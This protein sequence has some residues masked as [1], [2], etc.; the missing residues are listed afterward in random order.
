MSSILET[1]RPAVGRSRSHD[2]LLFLKQPDDTPDKALIQNL[3]LPAAAR[4]V[5]SLTNLCLASRTF[6][7]YE[8]RFPITVWPFYFDQSRA[9]VATRQ[10]QTVKLLRCPVTK[11]QKL[12]MWARMEQLHSM[13]PGKD[14]VVEYAKRPAHITP[15]AGRTGRRCCWGNSGRNCSSLQNSGSPPSTA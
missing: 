10:D 14:F 7:Q 11:V 1:S 2:A 8:E 5:E 3:W 12:S 4:Y 13:L 9:P 15:L 6:S